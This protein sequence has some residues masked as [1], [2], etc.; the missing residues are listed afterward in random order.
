MDEE[1]GHHV[2]QVPDN[3]KNL[4]ACFFCSQVKT[5]EQF[6][7]Y[8]CSN[9]EDWLGLKQNKPKIEEC[10]SASFE[11]MFALIDPDASWVA[12]WQRVNGKQYAKGMY[13]I[14]VNGNPPSSVINELRDAGKTYHNRNRA[15]YTSSR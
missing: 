8:G 2:S 14:S 6:D 1:N 7:M 15:V 3:M 10:T 12:R 9:C 11:G 13:A 5:S 4:R